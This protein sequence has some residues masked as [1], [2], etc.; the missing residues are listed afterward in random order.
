M[1]LFGIKMSLL[2]LQN[3]SPWNITSINERK[4][5]K[6]LKENQK[7]IIDFHRKFFTRVYP[8]GKRVDSSNYD[9][10]DSFNAGSQFIALNMQTN[11]LSLLLYLAKFV[12]NGG[13]ECGYVLKPAF[14]RPNPKK[15]KYISD[16]KNI[17]KIVN[18]LVISGQ[19]LRPE[20]ENDVKDVVDPYVEV[21]LRGILI[22]GIVYLFE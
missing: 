19:Q 15:E 13:N 4:I 17:R 11:D 3:R 6:Y 14:L 9:P 10:I 16:F 18:I 8:S 12:E 1:A 2:N 22:D 5:E 7:E 21:S 20:D